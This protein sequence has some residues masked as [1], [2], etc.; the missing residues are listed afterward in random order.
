M[1]IVSIF[2]IGLLSLSVWGLFFA[3]FL[4]DDEPNT[5][6]ELYV[7][8]PIEEEQEEDNLVATSE[9]QFDE[10]NIENNEIVEEVEE[11]A[12]I[13][14]QEDTEPERVPE[15]LEE[16]ASSRFNDI[17]YDFEKDHPVSVDDL[18]SLI[19]QS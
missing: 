2:S 14:E 9:T 5:E 17:L 13:I 16:K 11:L 4:L 12:E 7:E 10:E 1:R 6:A 15:T 18:L 8:E 19:N 3:V